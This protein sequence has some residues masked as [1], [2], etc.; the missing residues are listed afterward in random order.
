MLR[1][2]IAEHVIRASAAERL[3]LPPTAGSISDGLQLDRATGLMD[4]SPLKI[5]RR[6]ST[7]AT[8]RTGYLTS[9]RG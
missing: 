9:G 7:A 6:P 4:G 5:R 3:A 8:W 1:R 2:H